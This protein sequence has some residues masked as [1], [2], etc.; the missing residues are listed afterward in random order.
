[1][2][3]LVK[4]PAD[5]K[6]YEGERYGFAA[7][8]ARTWFDLIAGFKK[9]QLQELKQDL[10]GKTLV[11]EYCGNPDYQHLVKYGEITIFFYALVE[12]KSQYTCLPPPEAFR[13]L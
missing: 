12:H 13:I 4:E 9:D 3:I 10:T 7:L 6:A 1:M 5:I 2:S 8:I 11:G